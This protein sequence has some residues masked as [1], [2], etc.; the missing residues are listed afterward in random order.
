MTAVAF[1]F[2]AAVG[3]VARWRASRLNRADLPIGTLAVNVAAAFVLGLLHDVG[4]G[5]L[6][7]LGAGLLGSLSTFSTVV[8]EL[9]DQSQRGE[10]AR[11]AGYL[12]ATLLLGIGAAWLG[13]ELR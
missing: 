12:G 6:T 13:I 3:A 11:A 2:L 7:A 4:D 5:V 9:I 8:R 1:G 10:V